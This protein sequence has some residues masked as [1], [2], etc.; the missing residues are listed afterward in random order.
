MCDE[1]KWV[2]KVADYTRPWRE[3]YLAIFW[4]DKRNSG[5]AHNPF[6]DEQLFLDP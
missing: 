5:A 2:K 1:E 3:T 4:G 6:P